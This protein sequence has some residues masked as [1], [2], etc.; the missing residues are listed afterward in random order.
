L[1]C[2]TIKSI[3]SRAHRRGTVAM[4][5]AIWSRADGVARRGACVEVGNAMDAAT[6]NER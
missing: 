2:T 3:K 6:V 4:K 5:S 1:P